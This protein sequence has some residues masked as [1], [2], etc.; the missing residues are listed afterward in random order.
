MYVGNYPIAPSMAADDYLVAVVAGNLRRVTKP[1]A[2]LPPIGISDV[3]GLQAALDAKQNQIEHVVYAS[4]LSSLDAVGITPAGRAAAINAV[5]A[6]GNLEFVFDIPLTIDDG[7]VAYSNTILRWLGDDTLTQKS[8]GSGWPMIRNAHPTVTGTTPV[9]HDIYVLNL[10]ADNNSRN[11]GLGSNILGFPFCN[12][13]GYV[14]PVIA[15]SGVERCGVT[16]YLYDACAYGVRLANVRNGWVQNFRQDR[17]TPR[18]GGGDAFVQLQ[19]G[20]TGCR[21]FNLSGSVLDNAFAF[22]ANDGNDL[23]PSG[24]LPITFRPGWVAFGPITDSHVDGL[25]PDHCGSFMRLLSADAAAAITNCTFRNFNGEVLN[26]SALFDTFGI[27]GDGSRGWYD[28][29]LFENWHVKYT[30][31]INPVTGTVN[32]R[33][34]LNIQRANC[35]T[36]T[37]RNISVDPGY[38]GT[39]VRTTAGTSARRLVLRGLEAPSV[40]MVATAIDP[41][42]LEGT[43]T[44]IDVELGQ[45]QAQTPTIRAAVTVTNPFAGSIGTRYVRVRGDDVRGYERL[46]QFNYNGILIP[47][48]DRV[49]VAGICQRTPEGIA[50]SSDTVMARVTVTGC[51]SDFLTDLPAGSGIVTDSAFGVQAANGLPTGVVETF[52]HF[53][54]R[55]FT[56]TAGTTAIAADATACRRTNGRFT[57][58]HLDSAS[59][60]TSPV[61]HAGAQP[62]LSFDATA[63]QIVSGTVTGLPLGASAR[64]IEFWMYVAAYPSPDSYFLYYGPLV[65]TEL[66]GLG[67]T[68]TGALTFTQFGAG[69][70]APSPF[71]LGIWR[72]VIL[73]YNPAASSNKWTWYRDGVPAGQGDATTN[74]TAGDGKLHLGGIPGSGYMTFRIARLRIDSV[75]VTTTAQATQR[76][77]IAVGQGLQSIS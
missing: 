47:P 16:G 28:G 67:M 1:S 20:C 25:Y 61:W 43:I 27:P 36:I 76:F 7:L 3:T 73:T 52:T 39:L 75:A 60:P 26:E 65:A 53:L 59:V 56:D 30:G 15:F 42:L 77:L 2:S 48:P 23:P 64:T 54:G 11:L 50:V 37:A 45:V 38:T 46:A 62:Y 57:T 72:H 70:T 9:D 49:Q 41:V 40:P 58:A 4:N 33:P 13:L 19:G 71:L 68:S 29:I 18:T 34:A 24:P 8:N 6:I 22:N 12:A 74:T 66:V 21:L 44:E 51:D 31:A 17:Y 63:S 10:N 69:V 32:E 35:G 55:A 5:L 14:E